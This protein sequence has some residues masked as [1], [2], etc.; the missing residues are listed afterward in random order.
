MLERWVKTTENDTS[1]GIMCLRTI[2]NELDLLCWG[3][4]G[5]RTSRSFLFSCNRYN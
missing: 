3:V 4:L 2:I 1:P 5:R